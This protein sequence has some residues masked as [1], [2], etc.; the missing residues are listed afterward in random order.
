MSVKIFNICTFEFCIK[1]QNSQYPWIIFHLNIGKK[2]C[3][4]VVPHVL[5]G[6]TNGVENLYP[7]WFV[8]IDEVNLMTKNNVPYCYDS[9]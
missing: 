9:Y 8:Q 5:Y 7:T 3:L 6:S 4:C 2:T 1:L